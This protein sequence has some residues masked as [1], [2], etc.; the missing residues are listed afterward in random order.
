MNRAILAKQ[1]PDMFKYRTKPW[2]LELQHTLTQDAESREETP[3]D[4][5]PT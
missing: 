1:R 4:A 5:R 2:M 3:P